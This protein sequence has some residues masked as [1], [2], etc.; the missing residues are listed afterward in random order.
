MTLDDLLRQRRLQMHRPSVQELANLLAK[1]QRDLGDAMVPDLSLDGRFIAAYNAALALATAVLAAAGYRASGAAHHA[2][3]FEAL[4]IVMG[5]EL[6]TASEYYDTC[7]QK[8]NRALY[9]AIGQA[10]RTEVDELIESVRGLEDSV[11]DWLAENYP[12]L[13]PESR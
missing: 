4:P 3:V 7:R 10:T 13:L 1:A 6:R 11:R 8:R 2:T 5:E 9:D 12:D